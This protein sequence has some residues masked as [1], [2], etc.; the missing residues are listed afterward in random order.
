MFACVHRQR[1]GADYVRRAG[2]DNKKQESSRREQKCVGGVEWWRKNLVSRLELPAT[3]SKMMCR[4]FWVF[5]SPRGRDRKYLQ[6]PQTSFVTLR[7]P[8]LLS[9]YKKPAEILLTFFG[10]T[11]LKLHLHQ[12]CSIGSTVHDPTCSQIT[13]WFPL[14]CRCLFFSLHF[15]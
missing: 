13:S 11:A 14:K 1:V 6:M 2:S 10:Q 5:L 3:R 4:S 15:S 7:N 12:K 8:P 9:L